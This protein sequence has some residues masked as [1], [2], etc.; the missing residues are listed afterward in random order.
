MIIQRPQNL[1]F[2]LCAGLCA[3]AV[4]CFMGQEVVWSMEVLLT[5]AAA[6]VAFVAI[7]F[8][9]RLPVQAFLAS[10]VQ[11]LVAIVY[12]LIIYDLFNLSGGEISPKKGIE[13][14]GLLSLFVALVMAVEARRGVK[15][16]LSLVKSAGRLR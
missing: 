4:S 9:K 1:Y 16:D 11:V 13:W 14:W 15:K 6:V 2:L 7:F 8:F 5:I 12:V 10:A 3:A